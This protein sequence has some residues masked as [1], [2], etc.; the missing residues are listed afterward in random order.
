MS[1]K[2]HGA[3]KAHISMTYHAFGS[4]QADVID[5][6]AADGSKN[7]EEHQNKF[8]ALEAFEPQP[9]LSAVVEAAQNTMV[10]FL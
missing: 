10:S 3:D 6:V 8:E 5:E 9:H 7:G 1:F 4:H 2:S